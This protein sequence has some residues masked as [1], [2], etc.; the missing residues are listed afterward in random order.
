M[1]DKKQKPV[2]IATT[3]SATVKGVVVKTSV[4]IGAGV[5]IGFFLTLIFN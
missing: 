4:M 1:Q 5:L 2:L 3:S